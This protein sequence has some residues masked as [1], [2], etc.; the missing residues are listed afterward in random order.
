M[1]YTIDERNPER[2][3]LLARAL[4][5]INR[6]WHG[7]FRIRRVGA[8]S[9]AISARGTTAAIATREVTVPAQRRVTVPVSGADLP[10]GTTTAN[11]GTIINSDRPIVV[12]RAL[13]WNVNGEVWAAGTN[14]TAIRLY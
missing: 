6:V 14:A 5:L 3:Q 11:F 12:E 1:S 4:A 9:F 13:Y 2:Q 10:Q 7:L 8:R